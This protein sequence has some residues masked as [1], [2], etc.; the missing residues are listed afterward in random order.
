MRSFAMSIQR[1]CYRVYRVC[2]FD[3]RVSIQ[4]STGAVNVL[5]NVGHGG[6]GMARSRSRRHG[7]GGDFCPNLEVLGPCIS[8]R[9]GWNVVAAEVEEVV[10]PIV[11]R[12]ET[13]RLTG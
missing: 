4:A 12:Q 8:I 6:I 13:L 7:V 5:D 2:V 11:S 9:D 10:D 1:R 3:D